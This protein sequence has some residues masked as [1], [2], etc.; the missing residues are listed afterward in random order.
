[1]V[2]LAIICTNAFSHNFSQH[3]SFQE[4]QMHSHA[5]ETSAY[6]ATN[7]LSILYKCPSAIQI[8]GEYYCKYLDNGSI[9]NHQA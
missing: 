7:L 1:M 4:S 5:I 8:I 9:Y 3:F 6:V 2:I